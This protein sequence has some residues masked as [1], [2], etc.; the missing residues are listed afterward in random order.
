MN[1]NV[2]WLAEFVTVFA[3]SQSVN[4]NNLWQY[5]IS[6]FDMLTLDIV[7]MREYTNS[8]KVGSMENPTFNTVFTAHKTK[9]KVCYL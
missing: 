3:V 1:W 5:V 8:L 2:G 6:F 4:G 7:G 9:S